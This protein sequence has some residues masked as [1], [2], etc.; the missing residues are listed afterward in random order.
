MAFIDY[1]LKLIYKLKF[2]NKSLIKPN[3]KGIDTIEVMMRN[4]MVRDNLT[5]F[6]KIIP[7]ECIIE[8]SDRWFFVKK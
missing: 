1:F 4:E 6:V 7:D 5:E 8:L 3:S 2:S